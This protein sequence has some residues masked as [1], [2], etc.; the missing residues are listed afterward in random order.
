MTDYQAPHE[1]DNKEKL[2][3]MIKSLENGNELPAIIVIG[4][5]ALNGSHRLSAWSAM[6]IEPSVVEI[7]SDDYTATCESLFGDVVT[8]DEI[9][10][11]DEFCNTLYV[12]T[13]DQD[14]KNALR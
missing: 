5:I 6:E 14:V 13:D 2:N 10:D 9:Y 7:S 4:E 11:F 3:S 8:I 1:A 12:I